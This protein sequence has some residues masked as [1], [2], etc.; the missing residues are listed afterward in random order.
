MSK[1]SRALTIF[2]TSQKFLVPLALLGCIAAAMLGAVGW[3]QA[4]LGMGFACMAIV[5]GCILDRQ[6]IYGRLVSE[7]WRERLVARRLVEPVITTRDS[8]NSLASEISTV[9]KRSETPAQEPLDYQPHFANVTAQLQSIEWDLMAIRC[10]VPTS[11]LRALH[12]LTQADGAFG[13]VAFLGNRR[14]FTAITAELPENVK[15]RFQF[16]DAA[17]SSARYLTSRSAQ[18][19]ALVIEASPELANMADAQ[20]ISSRMLRWLPR[21]AEIVELS[22]ADVTVNARMR[23]SLAALSKVQ[24]APIE[25]EPR[26]ARLVVLLDLNE[27]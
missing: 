4:S 6:V 20:R 5:L 12:Q 18:W 13:P 23:D 14:T 8:V 16:I 27:S 24:L 2:R 3:W 7:I 17:D 22:A 9:R 15:K 26:L 1:Q 10:E 19:N 11:W 21:N 25:Q